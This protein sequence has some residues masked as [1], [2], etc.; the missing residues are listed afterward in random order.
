M[1]CLLKNAQEEFTRQNQR[2]DISRQGKDMVPC[3]VHGL[4]KGWVI[5]S[6]R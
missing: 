4:A 5:G 2:E 1:R 3:L 6:V